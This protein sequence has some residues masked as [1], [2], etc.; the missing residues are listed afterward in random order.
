MIR[1]D[2]GSAMSRKMPATRFY[3]MAAAANRKATER[4]SL[5]IFA[6]IAEFL[7]EN[8]SL[9]GSGVASARG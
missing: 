2:H 5:T 9:I 7:P 1:G 3:G 8:R 6:S 4:R